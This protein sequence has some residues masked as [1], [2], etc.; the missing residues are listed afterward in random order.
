MMASF[1]VDRELWAKFGAISKRERLTATDV[2]TDYIQ[3]CTS[4]DKTQY[5]ANTSTDIVSTSSVGVLTRQD[6]IDIV[7]DIVMTHQEI[8]DIA[9]AT[10]KD[11]IAQAHPLGVVAFEKLVDEGAVIKIAEKIVSSAFTPAQ[12]KPVRDNEPEWVTNDNRR[13][14]TKLVNDQKLLSKVTEV[15]PQYPK[16]N[17]A[18][19]TALVDVGWSK[20]DG[21]VL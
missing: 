3:R 9:A 17:S 18:L 19:A 15:I 14:Y 11:S 1:R 4:N 6:V 8:R 10:I 21:T 16:D 13:F 2:L 7:N 12:P 20:G 5:G